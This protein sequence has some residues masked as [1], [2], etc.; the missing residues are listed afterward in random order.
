M[1]RIGRKGGRCSRQA[2]PP[3][4]LYL[5]ILICGLAKDVSSITFEIITAPD[6]SI[7]PSVFPTTVPSITPEDFVSISPAS[8][9]HNIFDHPNH[10]TVSPTTSPSPVKD[11]A[12]T[13]SAKD[14]ALALAPKFSA[15]LSIGGSSFII[16]DVIG[17]GQAFHS[18][19]HRLLMGMS[20]CTL[21]VSSL[22]FFTST[23]PIPEHS[24]VYLAAGN[25][26]TCDAQGFFSQFSLSVVMYNASLSLYYVAKVAYQWHTTTIHYRLEPFLHVI[27]LAV[28]LGTA[29]AGVYLDLYNN[30]GGWECWIAA[31]PE[32]CVES[33]TIDGDTGGTC[34]RGDN[35]SIYRWVFYYGI[36]WLAIIFVLANMSQVYKSVYAQEKKMNQ[37]NFEYQRQLEKLEK[38][39]LEKILAKLDEESD[40]SES[41]ESDSGSVSSAY[42]YVASVASA[43]VS[44]GVRGFQSVSRQ[45]MRVLQAVPIPTQIPG[46][47]KQHQ[48]LRA[49]FVHSRRV[50]RQGYWFCGAFLAT[51]MFPTVHRLLQL[52]WQM[53][54]YS[55]H[56][57]TA[58]F[59]PI[60]GFF[61]F[62]VYIQTRI[63]KKHIM[64]AFCC[65]MWLWEN[66]N[67][68]H[69]LSRTQQ[70]RQ[71]KRMGSSIGDLD[72][73]DSSSDDDGAKAPDNLPPRRISGNKERYAEGSPEAIL[74]RRQSSNRSLD[75]EAAIRLGD[76]SDEEDDDFD[77][78]MNA[79]KNRHAAK[80]PTRRRLSSTSGR[81]SSTSDLLG[82]RSSQEGRRTSIG[83]TVTHRSSSGDFTLRSSLASSRRPSARRSTRSLYRSSLRES[84]RASLNVSIQRLEIFEKHGRSVASEL[85]SSMMSQ[86]L[87]DL[88]PSV[89]RAVMLEDSAD[90]LLQ[91]QPFEITTGDA[92]SLEV[93]TDDDLSISAA[94][95][96]K[97]RTFQGTGDEDRDEDGLH[98]L[99]ESISFGATTKDER[100]ESYHCSSARL[101]FVGD[102]GSSS[103]EDDASL[104]SVGI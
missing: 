96:T 100:P 44:M 25:Q 45:S 58:I 87:P 37:Y 102:M 38:E 46:M 50:S 72:S 26:A 32:D 82:R 13:H 90:R 53:D 81:R 68:M 71:R 101:R 66:Q 20:I 65:V 99:D 14:K 2:R 63:Q 62:V 9:A 91:F 30:G 75:L 54:I 61:N 77:D 33:W 41:D 34:I 48:S 76:T 12:A 64:N 29:S 11:E 51:W 19:H 94:D 73:S 60:Q 92:I 16:Y 40:D 59:V 103:S 5:L 52:G 31:W 74:N 83:D 88:G 97:E 10:T 35:A 95:G 28:G 86:A 47:K 69:S 4:L 79:T 23:W 98:S 57:L 56:L 18:T 89:E 15:F 42:S 84:V 93:D 7:A 24:G 55:L 21:L 36:L 8:H 49:H 27:P 3:A 43:S 6:P 67:P 104:D 22:A 70:R 1:M 80:L 17:T 39:R 78:D 85:T